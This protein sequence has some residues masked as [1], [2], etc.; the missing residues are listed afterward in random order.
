MSSARFPRSRSFVG[1]IAGSALVLS[2]CG[3]VLSACG[4]SG[5]STPEYS[6]PTDAD[7]V[8]KAVPTIRWDA[9][10]YTAPAGEINVFLANDDNVKHVLVVR[11]GDKV[12]GDLELVV[13]KRGDSDQGTITLEAGEYSVY[14]IIPGHGN[15][16]STL[17]VS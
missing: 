17:T 3:G 14:C 7:L 9:N 16:N 15:M 2:A 1:V 8:V 10:A 13:N 11:Q 5:A 4:G 12:V 6:I